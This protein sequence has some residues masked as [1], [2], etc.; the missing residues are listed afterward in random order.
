MTNYFSLPKDGDKALNGDDNVDDDDDERSKWLVRGNDF[1]GVEADNE[2]CGMVRPKTLFICQQ[3]RLPHGK[4]IMI[5]TAENSH[6]LHGPPCSSA[7][8]HQHLVRY[9]SHCSIPH[10]CGFFALR[11]I[12]EFLLL[13]QQLPTHERNVEI[14]SVYLKKLVQGTA[15]PLSSSCYCKMLYPLH[16]KRVG[17]A[18]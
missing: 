4:C 14:V 13:A 2:I 11:E 1:F 17:Q 3:E 6:V 5:T 10:I 7:Y 16:D 18:R 15:Q 8:L 12:V 9:N